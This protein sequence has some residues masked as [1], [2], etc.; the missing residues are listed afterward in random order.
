MNST[1]DCETF[2][3]LKGINLITKTLADGSRWT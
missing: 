2:V 3:R 1:M